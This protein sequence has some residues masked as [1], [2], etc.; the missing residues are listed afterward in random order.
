MNSITN[1]RDSPP[2]LIQKL[3]SFA[4]MSILS[5]KRNSRVHQCKW[6][7]SNVYR[8]SY[9]FHLDNQNGIWVVS[10]RIFQHKLKDNK[11]SGSVYLL[12]TDNIC[13]A[14]GAS[15][16][17]SRQKGNPF[18]CSPKYIWGHAYNNEFLVMHKNSFPKTAFLN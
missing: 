1:L 4:G 10:R 13:G 14:G 16:I 12:K 5:I 11:I 3:V 15:A 18:F 8:K 9:F 6:E 2:K 17:I 7:N